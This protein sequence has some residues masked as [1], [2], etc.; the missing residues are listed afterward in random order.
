MKYRINLQ[1]ELF[2]IH[3]LDLPHFILLGCAGK[4]SINFHDLYAVQKLLTTRDN[5]IF[6]TCTKGRK[7]NDDND[8]EKSQDRSR[9]QSLRGN[10]CELSIVQCR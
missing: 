10:G 4:F 6:R 8:N 9:Q 3:Y 5:S 2:T 7:E 1:V